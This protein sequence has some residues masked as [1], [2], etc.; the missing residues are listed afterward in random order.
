MRNE[1]MNGWGMKKLM[2]EE[3]CYEWMRNEEMNEWGMK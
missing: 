1:V 3:W 2:N